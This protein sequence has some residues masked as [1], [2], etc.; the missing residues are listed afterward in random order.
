MKTEQILPLKSWG[1][2][3]EALNASQCTEGSKNIR[4]DL[5]S[6][7]PTCRASWISN[8]HITIFFHSTG[9]KHC[10]LT[11]KA[12]MHFK[13]IISWKDLEKEEEKANSVWLIM[14][15]IEHCFCIWYYGN[16]GVFLISKELKGW[17]NKYPVPQQPNADFEGGHST[18]N[19]FSFTKTV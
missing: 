18:H 1:K 2:R 15:M 17:S 14:A 4:S 13:Q 9:K 8:P 6:N 7:R 5:E 3:D 10:L 12:C 11:R 16:N 19:Q